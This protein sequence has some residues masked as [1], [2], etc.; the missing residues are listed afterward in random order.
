MIDGTPSIEANAAVGTTAVIG[1]GCVISQYSL[2]EDGAVLGVGVRVGSAAVVLGGA[3]IDDSAV[4]G[5]NATVGCVHI[6]RGALIEPGAVVLADVPANA[7]VRGNPARIVAYV[8]TTAGREPEPPSTAARPAAP[9]HVV[10]G[11]D[12]LPVVCVTDLRGSLAAIEFEDLPFAPVRLFSVF[13]V[14]SE[15]LRGAHAHR[16]CSQFLVCLAGTLTCLVDDGNSRAEIVLSEPTQG[17]L[18]E[19]L[20][21]ATQYKYSPDAV[22][23]VLA[24]HPYDPEDYIRDYEEYLALIGGPS[25]PRGPEPRAS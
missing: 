6:G 7:I 21:W 9:S 1:S 13:A 3:R 17:L 19:P 14:P 15:F 10:R 5:S 23:A 4:V 25:G 22:L 12:L 2:V 8:E 16:Q 24:S 11:V 18:I 20:V